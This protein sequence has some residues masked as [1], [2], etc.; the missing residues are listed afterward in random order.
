[1]DAM[2]VAMLI[3]RDPECR[4]ITGN[5][6]AYRLLR[7]PPGSNLSKSIVDGKQPAYR[8][9]QG[10]KEIPPHELPL[11]KA[12]ATGQAV[13]EYELELVFQDGTKA[14]AIGNA[15]PLLDIEGRTRGAVGVFVDITERKQTE[16]RLRQAQ[17]LES[18]S[19]LAGGIA[20][21]FNNLLTVIIGNA[22]FAINKYPLSEE[23]QQ[24]IT[25]SEQAAQLT[26]QLLAY[27][28]KAHF[29][30]RTFSLTEL[31]SGSAER[32]SASVPKRVELRFNLSPEE[33][34]IKGEPSQI[35]QIL[36]NLVINASE[37]ISPQTDGRIEIATRDCVVT[38][39][40]IAR[41]APVFDV[42]PGHF[43]CL[44]VTDNGT[45][46]DEATLPRI[47]DPFFTTKFKGRGLGLAAVQGIARSCHGL[48][49]VRSSR[50][51]GSTF[52]VFLP[53]SA[54]KPAVVVPAVARPRTSRPQ[55][56]KRATVLVVEDE[57]MVRQM[58]CVALRTQ[59]YEVLEAKNGKDALE[60]LAG[61]AIM[62]SLVLLDLTMPV[63]G[64]DELLPILN[65]DYSGMPVILTS[66]YLEED[67]RR[68]FP[69]GAVADFLQKPYALT[70]L[71]EKVEGILNSGG[72]NVEAPLSA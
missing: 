19:L 61:A 1:M 55:D 42:Q 47:F 59:G 23:I 30:S 25:A 21:D 63:M 5:S 46:M 22:S 24:I 43:V 7:E 9:T 72:P 27:T 54:E 18:I 70:T 48:I 58:A 60:M 17:K 16:E 15:V 11:Q 64:G 52:R 33:L 65:H 6:T 50:G 10:G 34:L 36:M 37:A 38:P 66:G 32:L 44:E 28:G 56:H 4:Y 35:E 26:R 45:G 49:D 67:A 8:V 20:H 29:I 14:N 69:P 71:T 3:S 68:A 41:D 12:G 13:Y 53:A 31:V 62:P 57:E 40:T 2:P 51:A 39:E